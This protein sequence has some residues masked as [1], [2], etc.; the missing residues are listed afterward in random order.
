MP[1]IRQP[2]NNQFIATDSLI[3]ECARQR[4]IDN[5]HGQLV[6][7]HFVDSSTGNQQLQTNTTSSGLNS[8]HL[9]T[10]SKE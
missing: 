8:Q 7:P 6:M 3:V 10:D 9:S 5:N 4:V 2:S 1:T